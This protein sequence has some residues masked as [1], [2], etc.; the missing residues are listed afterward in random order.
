MIKV[1][2]LVH[3]L[4]LLSEVILVLRRDLLQHGDFM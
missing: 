1:V 2:P 3:E 4:V